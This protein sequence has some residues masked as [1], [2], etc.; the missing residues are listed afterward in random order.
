[1]RAFTFL[2]IALA[3]ALTLLACRASS[4]GE[5]E[6]P[7]GRAM[8]AVGDF[9]DEAL[10]KALEEGGDPGPL[11]A[12][13]AR[14][15]RLL[16]RAAPRAEAAGEAE[17]RRLARRAVAFFDDLARAPSL[18]EMRRMSSAAEERVCEA[19]HERYR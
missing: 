5:D 3:L 19:C 15:A 17:F 6:G 10:P 16:E 12:E 4:S 1:M 2:S 9:F 7:W 11:Q 14:L 18:A 13:A 8:S